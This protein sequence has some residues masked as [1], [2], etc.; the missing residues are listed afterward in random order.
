VRLWA[1]S[2]DSR[3]DMPVSKEALT[4]TA[5][6]YR[7]IRNTLRFLL[8]NLGDF[9][10][11]SDAVPTADLEPV[12]ACFLRRGKALAKRIEAAYRDYEFHVAYRALNNFCAVDLSAVYLDVLKDR[13]YCSHPASPRRRSAQTVLDR[14]ARMLATTMAPV[15]AFTSDEVWEHLPGAP[16]GSLHLETFEMLDDVADEP[17]ADARFARLLALRDEVNKEL[18]VHRQAGEFGKSLEAVLL[19]GG[20]LKALEADLASAR[21]TLEELCIV[22]QA[23]AGDGT[24][25]SA[26]YPGLSLGVRRAEGTP[27]P[28]CWQVWPAPAGHPQHPELCARCLGVVLELAER[29]PR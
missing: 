4:R 18:E 7:K 14:L 24:T 5:D 16:G 26:I 21:V 15:L 1:A 27:C 29:P 28:R 10:P 6:A 17:E 22:S 11:G 9:E 25:S 3:E 13:L 2:V 8:S 19:L 23:G 20:D 12:D